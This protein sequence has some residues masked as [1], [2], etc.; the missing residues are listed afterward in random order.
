MNQ[1]LVVY[2]LV[3]VKSAKEDRRSPIN[4][5]NLYS[6]YL[7]YSIPIY[8]IVYSIYIMNS[9]LDT[10]K[11]CHL[12]LTCTMTTQVPDPITGRIPFRV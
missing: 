1:I 8:Y 5:Q 9:R 6:L 10:H 2:S 11:R 12:A 3:T 4:K 7:M